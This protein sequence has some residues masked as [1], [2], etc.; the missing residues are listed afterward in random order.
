MSLSTKRV[1]TWLKLCS[2]L[3]ISPLLQ[4]IYIS[5]ITDTELVS[6]LDPRAELEPNSIASVNLEEDLHLV[7]LSVST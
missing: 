2:K 5:N 4:E 1:R 3:T 7:N 6:N